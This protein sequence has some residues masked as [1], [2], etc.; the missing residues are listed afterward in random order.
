MRKLAAT[1]GLLGGMAAWVWLAAPRGQ[2]LHHFRTTG[3]VPSG[4]WWLILGAGYL[5][6]LI[7][8][9]LGVA[10]RHLIVR[11]ERP[12]Y[13]VRFATLVKETS[14]SPDLWVSMLGS[15]LLYGSIL[16]SGADLATGAFLYFALQSGFSAY[17][18]I[19]ALLVTKPEGGGQ[20]A[21][22]TKLGA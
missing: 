3:E 5:V 16:Q 22:P 14:G 12:R 6:L 2:A 8:I 17:V 11:R 1:F 20:D 10:C 21:T 9:C 7:G 15:P 18:T 19:N 13:R 4:E